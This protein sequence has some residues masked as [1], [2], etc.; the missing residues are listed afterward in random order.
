VWVSIDAVCKQVP[1]RQAL[2]DFIA[3]K[4]VRQRGCDNA[5]T[6]SQVRVAKSA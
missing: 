6:R 2:L 3:A 1:N 4:E 5:C